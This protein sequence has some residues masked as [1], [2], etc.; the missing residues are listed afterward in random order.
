MVEGFLIISGHRR[1]LMY[2]KL[3]RPGDGIDFSLGYVFTSEEVEQIRRE[4]VSWQIKPVT[5][6]PAVYTPG[7]QRATI[8]GEE[9]PF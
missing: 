7:E 2:A 3:W 9:I 4:S 8:T 1:V 6:I 5:K